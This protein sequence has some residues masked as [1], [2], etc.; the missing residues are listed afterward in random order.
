MEE[1]SEELAE[2]VLELETMVSAFKSIALTGKLKVSSWN[3]VEIDDGREKVGVAEL[4]VN[5]RDLLLVVAEHEEEGVTCSLV[6][7]KFSDLQVY[8]PAPS[9]LFHAPSSKVIGTPSF[10]DD[11]R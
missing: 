11:W 10:K 7:E 5:G 8:V 4:N 9:E 6:S 1:A 3:E 2:M